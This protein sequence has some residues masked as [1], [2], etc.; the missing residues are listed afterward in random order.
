VRCPGERIFRLSD[1][2]PDAHLQPII[3]ET[4]SEHRRPQAFAASQNRQAK[5]FAFDEA[6]NGGILE[7]ME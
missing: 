4:F 3:S 6:V 5:W 1:N 7:F 2:Y